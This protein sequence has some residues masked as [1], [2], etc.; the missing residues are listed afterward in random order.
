[1]RKCQKFILFLRSCSDVIFRHFFTSPNGFKFH[2]YTN[3]LYVS[4][5]DDNT[6]C[7]FREFWRT[8]RYLI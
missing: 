1:M 7:K 6:F 8:L 2:M 5:V 4:D 3:V